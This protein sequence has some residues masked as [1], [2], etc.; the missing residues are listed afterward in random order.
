MWPQINQ[1]F[2]VL[3]A[4]DSVLFLFPLQ[5]RHLALA[6]LHKRSRGKKEPVGFIYALSG[7]LHSRVFTTTMHISN[8]GKCFPH[9][10]MVERLHLF[11]I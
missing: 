7:P 3:P 1:P 4:L 9:L 8:L 2:A 6:S 10:T 11:D 5:V